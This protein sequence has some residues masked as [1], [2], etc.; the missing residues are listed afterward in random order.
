MIYQSDFLETLLLTAE[1]VA[2]E[3]ER[4]AFLSP[5]K[6]AEASLTA[7]KLR[8]QPTLATPF[9]TS[10][11]LFYYLDNQIKNGFDAENILTDY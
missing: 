2:S 11:F 8:H 4:A 1:G 3:E 9:V 10:I 7:P 6:D 5:D